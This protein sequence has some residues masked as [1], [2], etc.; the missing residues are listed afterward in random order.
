MQEAQLALSSG[1]L[2]LSSDDMLNIGK[3]LF[4]RVRRVFFLITAIT[5]GVAFLPASVLDSSYAV[6]GYIPSIYLFLSTVIDHSASSML[7]NQE[8]QIMVSSPLSVITVC[9]ELALM[10][11]FVLNL[12]I[13]V[14]EFYQFLEPGLYPH[15][16]KMLKEAVGLVIVLFA[17]GASIAYFVVVPIMLRILTS[18]TIPLLDFGSTPMLALFSLESIFDLVFWTVIWT[19]LLYTLPEII[20]ILVLLDLVDVKY[21]EEQ[22]KNVFL[23]ILILAAIITPDPTLVSMLILSIPLILI[24]Q[25]IIQRGYTNLGV[26]RY[27]FAKGVSYGS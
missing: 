18:T 25:L 3:E 8:V 26:K 16:K 2:S 13:L 1:N 9:I 7:F 23:A 15:E 24:Y 14:Y 22:K 20:Y 4:V 21:L 11:S 17:I 12:P 27:K 10:I 6:H 19:G 5:F